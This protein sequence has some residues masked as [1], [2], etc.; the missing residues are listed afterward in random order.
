MPS[1]PQQLKDFVL[2]MK[3]KFTKQEASLTR[4]EAQRL[5][6]KYGTLWPDDCYDIRPG[7]LDALPS[8]AYRR[9]Y[10]PSLAREQQIEEIRR[11][12]AERLASYEMERTRRRK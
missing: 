5:D 6:E 9:S 7:W 8:F 3:Q 1:C 11:I 2:D 10:G 4:S 12:H